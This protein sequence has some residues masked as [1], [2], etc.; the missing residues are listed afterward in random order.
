MSK[1]VV[2]ANQTIDASSIT[3]ELEI[4]RLKEVKRMRIVQDIH[5]K[6]DNEVYKL[7]GIHSDEAF[8]KLETKEDKLFLLKKR[9]KDVQSISEMNKLISDL[10]DKTEADIKLFESKFEAVRLKYTF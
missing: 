5:S 2:I 9:E 7:Q 8:S 4:L 1:K 10:I 3:T 6:I